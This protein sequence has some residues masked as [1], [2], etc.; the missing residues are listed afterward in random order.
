MT[1][2][3]LTYH[4]RRVGGGGFGGPALYP[5]EPINHWLGRTDNHPSFL[6]LRAHPTLSTITAEFT[7]GTSNPL[8][9][10]PPIPEYWIRVGITEVPPGTDLARLV[11]DEPDITRTPRPPPTVP[12]ETGSSGWQA[13]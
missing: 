7:D 12:T 10:S 3:E 9:I 5:D 8:T 4:G 1:F 2:V 6:L 11:H 13:V